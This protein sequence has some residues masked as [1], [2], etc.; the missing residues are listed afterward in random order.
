MQ[1]GRKAEHEGRQQRRAGRERQD[2]QV[3]SRHE[4]QVRGIERQE[5]HQPPRQQHG[6]GHA[7][8]PAGERQ[9]QALHQELADELPPARAERRLDRH[10]LLSGRGAREQQVRDVRARDQQHEAH[11]PLED[12]ER[13]LEAI[14]QVGL[15]A[16]GRDEQERLLQ[17]ALP[18]VRELLEE[19]AKEFLLLA[20]PIQHAQRGLRLFHRHAGLQAPEHVEPGVTLVLE[21]VPG[22]RD[23][24]LHHHGHPQV[25][26]DPRV[27][28]L[29]AGVGDADDGERAAVQ[30]DRRAHDVG[31][32]AEAVPPEVV[33]Q[34]RDRVAVLHGVVRH[35]QHTARVRANPEH[36]EEVA[37]DHA[38]VD[39]LVAIVPEQAR[40]LDELPGEA[41]EH[42]V[43]LTQREVEGMRERPHAV[44]A[45]R[46]EAPAFDANLDQ[47]ARVL[48]GQEAQQDL[49]DQPEHRRVRADA[50][51]Q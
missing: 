24:R 28:A 46:A 2:P 44:A 6:E 42:R 19:L 47:L 38:D 45:V 51:R 30:T 1:R 25:R 33:L 34:H 5:T 17:E 12:D 31:A 11:E 29:E 40:L 27:G 39:H 37:G 7:G 36:V 23:G 32:R 20:L 14:P 48:D 43:L 4:R 49:I 10:L 22:G 50:E 15:P 18:R 3:G 26:G 16:R 13:L 35:V 41:R 8:D 21:L 9:Q